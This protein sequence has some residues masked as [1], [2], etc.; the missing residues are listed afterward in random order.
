M[1]N[2]LY[3]SRRQAVVEAIASSLRS[4]DGSGDFLADISNSV[5]TRFLFWDD[6]SNFPSVNLTASSES[7]E[8]QG[9][10][11]KDR[12]LNVTVRISVREENANLALEGLIEDIET[13]LE[14]NSQLA[15]TD[16]QGNQQRIHQITIVSITTDEGVL[17][18]DGV[19]EIILEVR[20]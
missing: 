20:Y 10:G 15:Y 13:V 19:G 17:E 16:R 11:Y 1:S 14:D 3:T 8:Y 7:R 5:E 6:I 4:I 9:G 18:P 2:R 12:F